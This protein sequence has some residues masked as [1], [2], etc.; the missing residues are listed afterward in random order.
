MTTDL[1]LF[2][3]GQLDDSR[4]LPELII[5]HLSGTMMYID[6]PDGKRFYR[7]SDW[8]YEISGSQNKQRSAP[9]KDVKRTICSQD[10]LNLD[11]ILYAIKTD[12]SGGPQVCEFATEKGLFAITFRISD[13]SPLVRALKMYLNGNELPLLY[14][15]KDTSKV[16]SVGLG[17]IEV[18]E[19]HPLV[20]KHYVE[21]G[22]NIEHHK[23]LQSGKI[24]DIIATI[25]SNQVIIVECKPKLNERTLFGAIGQVLCYCAEYGGDCKPVIACLRGTANQYAYQSCDRLGIEILEI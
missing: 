16:N 17:R 11:D 13:R 7:V 9:W 6:Q 15:V 20:I 12:T 23:P 25:D 5:D 10:D 19:I 14:L 21:K 18:D 1:E 8:V 2:L 4:P 3:N 24:V 22:W